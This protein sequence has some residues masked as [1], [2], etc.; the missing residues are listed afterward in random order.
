[1][2]KL[3]VTIID[4]GVGNLL[5]VQRGF[6]YCGAKVTL[7]SKPDQI[8]AASRVVLPGVG[9]FANGMKALDVQQLLPVI[10]EVAERGTPFLGICL[11]M[12]LLLD[13]SD[14]FGLSQGLGL[15][16]G[17]VKVIPDVTTD[18]ETLKIPHIGWNEIISPRHTDWRGTL[19]SDNHPDDA[20][21]FVH[22]FMAT[23]N[24]NAHR[25]ADCIYGGHQIAAVIH[26]EN[27][28]GCQFHP[29]KSGDKGLKVLGQFLNL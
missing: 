23:P 24:D 10:H 18:G 22:S 4:Y 14:E 7:A 9:A 8:L 1:M 16:S 11:G 13:Q 2:S 12:Q 19:L 5:S 3:D 21:Y 15:I 26:R 17:H 25:L 6:E 29:E 27:I 20:M 28:M